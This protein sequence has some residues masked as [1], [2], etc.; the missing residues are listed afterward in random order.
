[1]KRS[2]KYRKAQALVD[3][4]KAYALGAAI[5]LLPKLST[6]EFDSSVEIHMNLKLSEK[7]KK[8]ST[9]GSVILPHQAEASTKI[10]VITTP[11]HQEEAKE[12]DFVGGE[13]LI[14]KIENGWSDF[15]IVIATPEIMPKVAVLG[16]LLGPKGKMP[17]PKTKTVTTDLKST[18]ENYKRGKTDF[19]A[20]KQGGIHKV[21][22]KVTM[23]KEHL[24]ENV[25]V[26]LKA[27]LKETPKTEGLPFKSVFLTP[28]M[29]P[30]IKLDVTS[31]L[32]I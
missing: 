30:S 12:A 20:D 17:N 16:K 29:G 3:K 13:D 28:T 31:L 14:K 26:F 6:A 23:K 18:I 5:E 9:R 4:T 25:R 32:K 7:Q 1:M 24:L 2:K 8:G 11:E 15:D 10:A 19:K 21:I 27:V 22:G